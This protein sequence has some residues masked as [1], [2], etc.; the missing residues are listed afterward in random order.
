MLQLLLWSL[1]GAAG[2]L[3]L[4]L[5]FLWLAKE[6]TMGICKFE[7]HRLDGKI[8]VITGGTSGIGLETAIHLAKRGC[9]LIIGYRNQR[10]MK[11]AESIIE[12]HAPEAKLDFLELQLTSTKS[13]NMFIE[14]VYALTSLTG[15]QILINNAGLFCIEEDSLGQPVKNYTEDGFELVMGVNYFGHV[16]L[17]E[18]LLDLLETNENAADP[19]RIITLSSIGHIMGS[20]DINDFDLNA[21]VRPYNPN[22]QYNA[23]KMALIHWT[24]RLARDLR[25][26]RKNVVCTSVNPG[27]VRTNIFADTVP[28]RVKYFMEIIFCILGKNTEQGCQSVLHACL[29]PRTDALN[30]YYLSDCRQEK[31]IISSQVYNENAEDLLWEYTQDLISTVLS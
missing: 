3:V 9:H 14:E 1:L 19:G 29:S 13:I 12:S 22:Y 17:T 6:L 10:K 21:N 27:L 20:L 2:R 26:S 8:A 25:A 24:N 31:L 16:I 15:I 23:S 30:G 28:A 4:V 7:N 18:G 5:F 11:T